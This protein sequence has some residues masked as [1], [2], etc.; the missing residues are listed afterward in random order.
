MERHHQDGSAPIASALFPSC[1]HV[2]AGRFRLA[3]VND[4]FE[5]ELA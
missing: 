1:L 3:A 2:A 5:R 4:D